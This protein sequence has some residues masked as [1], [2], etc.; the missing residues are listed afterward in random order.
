MSINILIPDLERDKQ[1]KQI[2]QSYI[3][4]YIPIYILYTDIQYNSTYSAHWIITVRINIFTEQET[5][6]DDD[7]TARQATEKSFQNKNFS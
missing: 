6:E 7:V 2:K 4:N 3:H 1:Q 5:D